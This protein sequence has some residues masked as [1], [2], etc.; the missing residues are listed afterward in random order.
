[1]ENVWQAGQYGYAIVLTPRNQ[2]GT[3]TW[4]RV[5][6]VTFSNNIVRHASGVMQLS[7]YDATYPSQQTQRVT[8]PQQSLLRHRS[9]EVGRQ[10]QGVPDR[11]GAG[12]YRDRS[13]HADSHQ[14]LRRVRLRRGHDHAGSS[15]RTTSRSTAAT[16]SWAKAAAP[17]STRIDKYFP[18]STIKYNVLAGGSASAYPTPNSFPTLTQW[19]ASFVD[20]AGEDYR[21]LSTSVFYAAGEGGTVPG[22]DLGA[23]Y[24]AVNAGTST[25]APPPGGTTDPAPAPSNVA[26]TADPGGP[27]R[28]NARHG[29]HRRRHRL[30]RRGWQHRELPLDLGGRD[31]RARVRCSRRRNRRLA[32]GA[33]AGERRGGRLG[34]AQ[35]QRRAAEA[36]FRRRVPSQLRRGPLLRRG[37]RAVSPLVP[38]A[39][40]GGLVLERLDV[41]PVQRRGRCGRAMPSTASARPTP[42]SSFSKTGGMPACRAGGGTT[43]RMARSRTPCTSRRV[44]VQTV[45]VQQRED[46]IMW[47]QIVLSAAT[48]RE[49]EPRAASCRYDRSSRSR[50]RRRRWRRTR[51]AS[52]GPIRWSSR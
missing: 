8:L 6:D 52:P 35:S 45:R 13:Q 3:S 4:V 23:V 22:A 17:G 16:A 40:R 10:R 27:V 26:P 14:Q 9:E 12:R 7:G 37:R 44:G 18:G 24:T 42:R 29:R 39:R 21:L 30:G 47:D 38:H 41:R 25:T 28:R 5:R 11:R 51:T 32:V 46:G 19:N 2:Y 48:Y 33:R 15:T 50:P 34:P 20:L 1:M 49:G 36:R 43:P 31:R